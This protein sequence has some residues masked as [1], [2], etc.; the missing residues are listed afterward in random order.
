MSDSFRALCAD[1]YINLKLGLKLDLPR[2]R[3]TVLDMFDRV[4]RQFPAMTQFKRYRDEL[5]LETGQGD[6][7]TRWVSI[8]N[9]S[10]RSGSVNPDALADAYALHRHLLETAPYYLGI[11]PLDVD[12]I[13][14]LFG[15]DLTASGNHDEIVFQALVAGSPLG[16]APDMAGATVTDC[17]P[18]FGIS[19]PGRDDEP[20]T[21]AVFEIKTR[22]STPE[23]RAGDA[24]PEPISVYLTLR[25]AGPVSDVTEL[26]TVLAA[27]ASR[28][29]SLVDS[30]VVPNLVVP[31]RD[32][33]SSGHA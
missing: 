30:R 1:F 7:Q 12:F 16:R 17:Q 24:P 13:E 18:V 8:R 10:V 25:R 5:A 33:I 6:P 26:P 32:A 28:G 4:R 23:A 20:P 3:Q 14:I 21:E 15:F 9:T 22:S 2:E 29:E 19:F 11:S 27:L 31:I